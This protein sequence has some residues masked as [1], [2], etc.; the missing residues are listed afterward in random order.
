MSQNQLEITVENQTLGRLKVALA[1]R[2]DT[3]TYQQCE[4]RLHSLITPG[5]RVLLLDLAGLQYLSSMGLRVLMKTNKA[6]A[7]LGG[8]CLLTRLQPPI[9][10]VIDIANALPS[11][12][13]FASVEEADHY[14]DVIQQRAREE[15]SGKP[16]AA[17]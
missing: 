14:L 8:K 3:A 16:P 7:A 17:L 1:G 11:T 12:A 13:I 4:Q 15:A 9:R 10:A 2:L 5:T 6:M